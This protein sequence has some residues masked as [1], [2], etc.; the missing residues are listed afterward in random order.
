[1]TRASKRIEAL[2]IKKFEQEK[3]AVV[4]K[5]ASEKAPVK[6]SKPTK[7]ITSN[8]GHWTELEE[9]ALLESLK[10]H[11]WGD[12]KSISK[13]IPSR[14]RK[15]IFNKISNLASSKPRNNENPNS[16]HSQLIEFIA[17]VS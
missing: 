8:T 9:T 17:K 16:V 15:K 10:K 2:A 11:D 5:S 13:D 12:W 4:E 7:K 3:A 1:M 6:S 14:S